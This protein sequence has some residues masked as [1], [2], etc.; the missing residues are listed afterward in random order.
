M[1]D[2]ILCSEGFDRANSN[3][4][5]GFRATQFVEGKMYGLWDPVDRAMK[6]HCVGFEEGLT[7]SFMVVEF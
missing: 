2:A 3:R 6:T 4:L 5:V 1:G 7:R